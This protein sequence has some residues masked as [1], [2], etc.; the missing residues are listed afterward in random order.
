MKPSKKGTKPVVLNVYNYLCTTKKKEG[1]SVHSYGVCICLTH[2]GNIWYPFVSVGGFLTAG[3]MVSLTSNHLRGFFLVLNTGTS[4][5]ISHT[6]QV[7]THSTQQ[8]IVD[9][10]SGGGFEFETVGSTF[11]FFSLLRSSRS[12]RLVCVSV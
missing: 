3:V 1:L 11:L 4:Y 6:L 7:C 10:G 2:R 5:Y 9:V 8:I 12:N